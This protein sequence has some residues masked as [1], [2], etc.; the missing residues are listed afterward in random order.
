M[1]FNLGSMLLNLYYAHFFLWF[2]KGV[3]VFASK[4]FESGSFLLQYPGE[5]ITE[6]EADERE[7]KY[8]RSSKGCYMYF[9]EH[10]DVVRKLSLS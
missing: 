9:F 6:A 8:T 5:L 4:S 3:G 2:I 10:K 7:K 1:S